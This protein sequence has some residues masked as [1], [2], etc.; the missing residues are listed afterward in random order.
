VS[1]SPQVA[2]GGLQ[3]GIPCAPHSGPV[4]VELFVEAP[5]LEAVLLEVPPPTEL[6]LT[7]LALPLLLLLLFV[8]LLLEEPPLP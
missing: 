7:L 6:L 4:L 2:A 8:E 3:Q 1:P 5:P